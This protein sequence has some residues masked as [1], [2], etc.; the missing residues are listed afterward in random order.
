M[1]TVVT[2]TATTVAV[3]TVQATKLAAHAPAHANNSH[4]KPGVCT[5]LYSVTITVIYIL[6]I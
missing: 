3:Y 2:S 5:C 6:I 1:G 4:Q